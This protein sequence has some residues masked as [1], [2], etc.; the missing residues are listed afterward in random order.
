MRS[1]LIVVVVA[2]AV[3]VRVALRRRRRGSTT[4]R[5]A[6]G[7][8]VESVVAM[9]AGREIRQ[10]LR[11]RVFRVVTILILLV[12]A[13]AIIIPTLNTSKTATEHVVVVGTLD[14]PA[15]SGLAN[16]ASA[17]GVKVRYTTESS[18][19][20]ARAD[21]ASGR[22]DVVVVDSSS[23][24]VNTTISP[25]DSSATAQFVGA[26]AT[27]VGIATVMERAHLTA[28]QISALIHATSVR[29]VSV[30]RS[31][32]T[33]P[34]GTTIIGLILIFTMLSQYETWTLTGVMEEK[35]SRV[36]EV[37]LATVRPIQLMTGKVLGI[38]AVALV[39]AAVIV[40]FAVALAKAVGS[41]FIHGAEPWVLAGTV[42]WLFLGYMF[43]C[44]IYAAAGAMVERQDQVQSLALP[45]SVPLLFGYVASLTQVIPGNPSAFLKVLAYLPP[46]APFAMTALIGIGAAT[47]W[48]YTISVAIDVV[49]T[50][51][52]AHVAASIYRRA[53]LRTGARVKF[54]DVLSRG[55]RSVG[56]T[57]P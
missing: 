9:V 8:G 15:A 38:G 41:S 49:C 44:W 35:S 56:A 11:G 51:G 21:L 16:A 2:V 28:G 53:I 57:A 30:H 10:R 3:I 22:V 6:R 13:A 48:Q 46:T 12:V 25:T 1:A 33:H 36:I 7:D 20:A 54:R 50:I 29:V 27:D 55:R 5:T 17:V 52:M 18:P 37:L 19:R 4:R 24:L 14:A 47:W 23:L 34:N 45:L 31:A 26:A 43:Y 40:G 42:L 32:P 39:Q